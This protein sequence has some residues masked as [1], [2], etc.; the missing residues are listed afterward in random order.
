[1]KDWFETFQS[2]KGGQVLLGNNKS[3]KIMGIGTVRIKQF[4]GVERILQQVRYI[5]GLKRNPVSLG[6]L[7]ARGYTYKALGGAIRIMR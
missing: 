3:C 6:T 4:D 2:V 1:M 5:L 7:D